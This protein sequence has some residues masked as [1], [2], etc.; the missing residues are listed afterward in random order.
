M[1]TGEKAWLEGYD[2]VAEGEQDEHGVDL[3]SLRQNLALT[4][5]ERYQRYVQGAENVLKLIHAARDSGF[6]Q[7]GRGLGL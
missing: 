3:E 6:T 1:E 2:P 4:P 5:T 7:A